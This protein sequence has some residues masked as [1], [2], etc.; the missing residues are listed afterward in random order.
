MRF[1][2]LPNLCELGFH[3]GVKTNDTLNVNVG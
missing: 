3:Y 2:H 1:T